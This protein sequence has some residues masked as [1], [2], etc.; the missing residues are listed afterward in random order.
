MD[1]KTRLQRASKLL[2]VAQELHEKQAD[3]IHELAG[4][5]GG[6]APIGDKLKRLENHF[7][8]LWQERYGSPYVWNWTKDRPQIKRLLKRTTEDDIAGR[9]VSYLFDTDLFMARS[10][11]PFPIFVARF[12]SYVAQ[13][14]A[15]LSLE[16]AA[17]L[18]CR[19]TPHCQ[20]DAEHTRLK[21]RELRQ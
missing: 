17:P 18:D 14:P 4:I 20:S 10:R 7:S 11:H 21:L 1:D 6:E 13:S 15:A 2:A 16:T 5:L 3:V 9:M 12:N 19:H 8:D